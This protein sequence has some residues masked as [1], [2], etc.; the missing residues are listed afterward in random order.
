MPAPTNISQR[1]GEG[2]ATAKRRRLI[3]VLVELLFC[4]VS[5]FMGLTW[6]ASSRLICP[7]REPLQDYQRHILDHAVDHGLI[8]QP[9]TVR[10]SDGHDTPCLLCEPTKQPGPALKGNKV[11]QELQ[12]T[13]VAVPSWGDVKG[14]L[15]LLHGHNG[16]KENHLAV[17]ER[18]C[19]VGFRCILM[20]LPGH[21][22]HPA[23]FATFG[24]T[25]AKLPQEILDAASQ[26]FA[27]PP[28]PAGLFG[29]SQGGAI[30][31]QSAVRPGEH[32]F[33]VAELS[34][35]SSLDEVIAEQ[36]QRWFGPLQGPARVIV[37]WLVEHRAG[38]RPEEA[39]P[40]RAASQLQQHAVLIGHGDCDGFIG[41]AH[42][43]RLYA[44][45]PSSRKQ[46]LNVPSADHHNVLI[47]STPVYA[48]LSAF[49]LKSLAAPMAPATSASA[50]PPVK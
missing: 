47:T 1:P 4:A 32:W 25:E 36:A 49:F 13:G 5:L 3:R 37:R 44:A 18:L 23:K 28:Q 9:F 40:V 42:A 48:T 50:T 7:R 43:H 33:A 45:V 11:R 27:F 41:Y 35:F 26:L 31:L 46:F 34:A 10:T 22:D 12:A 21:G 16:R 20:D 17:A 38:F 24:V 8:I 19:A 2:I 6:M 39:A 14:T 29:I 15:V 30:A